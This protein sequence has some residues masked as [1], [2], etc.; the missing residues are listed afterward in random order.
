MSKRFNIIF[1]GNYLKEIAKNLFTFSINL[2]EN[3]LRQ[4][5]VYV[6]KGK[7]RNILIDT[8]FNRPECQDALLAGLKELDLEVGD[9]DLVLTHLHSD[10]T[11]LMNLFEE[12]GRQI[13]L[14]TVDGNIL[15]WSIEGGMVEDDSSRFSQYGLPQSADDIKNHQGHRYKATKTVDFQAIDPGDTFRVGDYHFEIVDLIGHT[16][17]HIGL[18][19]KEKGLLIGGDTVLDPITP[20]ITYWNEKYPNI[21][22]TYIETLERIKNWNLRLILPG[23][24]N[25]IENPNERIDQIISH[26]FDRLQEI[27]D[28]MTSNKEYTIEEIGSN[29]SWRIRNVSWKDFPITQKWFALGETMS[30]IDYLAHKD[31]VGV[32]VDENNFFRVRKLGNQLIL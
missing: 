25:L 32:R 31:L 26:H 23:H 16:P 5:N 30:H 10:H 21:L 2:P 24:R 11:G 9:L 1:G 29:I 15:N 6:I 12:A 7:D 3:P 28:A 8:G 17:G 4:L 20:N 18:Y 22:G 27:L 13:Y 19:D 14:S